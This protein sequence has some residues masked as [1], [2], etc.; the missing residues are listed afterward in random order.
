MKRLAFIPSVLAL[1]LVACG[2]TSPSTAQSATASG[3]TTS[4]TSS[5]PASNAG[6]A[7]QKTGQQAE[8]KAEQPTPK[9]AK[10]VKKP[11]DKAPLAKSRLDGVT[12]TWTYKFENTDYT[13]PFEGRIQW[14]KPVT[15]NAVTTL[16]GTRFVCNGSTTC[17]ENGSVTLIDDGKSLR[18]E[19]IEESELCP[20][21]PSDD[22]ERVTGMWMEGQAESSNATAGMTSIKGTGNLYTRHPQIEVPFELRSA[23]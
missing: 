6:Q 17:R 12:G 13:F 18:V 21:Y 1:T 15:K 11:A 14:K 19:M 5:Q 22:C 8:Q 10:E 3:T 4:Q 9:D 7:E 20:P 23:K 16:V 2:T